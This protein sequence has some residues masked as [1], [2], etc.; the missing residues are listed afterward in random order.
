MDF[1]DI[2]SLGTMYQYIV[3]IE[4]KIKQKKRDAGY[5]NPKQGKGT[6]KPQNKGPSQGDGTQDKPLKLQANKNT[7]KMKKDM[8]KWCEFHKSSTHNTSECQAKQ[9]LVADL[10]ASESDAGS[11]FESKPNKGTDKGK[12]IIDVEPSAIMATTKIPKNEPDDL[13]EGERL[14]HSQMWVKGSLL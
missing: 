6:P 13:E 12:Q 10:K 7:L 3:K 8:G 9:S 5:T 1:L 2:S 11:D 4:Q 14:F